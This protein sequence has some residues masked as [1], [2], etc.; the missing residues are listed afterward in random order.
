VVLFEIP[1]LDLGE[2][3]L[4]LADFKAEPVVFGSLSSTTGSVL[5]SEL[6]LF[7]VG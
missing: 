6:E 3:S 1:D 2:L 7:V 4:W 5:Q